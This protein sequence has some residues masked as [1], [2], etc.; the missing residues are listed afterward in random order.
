MGVVPKRVA[1]GHRRTGRARCNFQVIGIYM[2]L[3]VWCTWSL[4][5][6]FMEFAVDIQ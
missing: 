3:T 1:G 6:E 5:E 2:N 4:H